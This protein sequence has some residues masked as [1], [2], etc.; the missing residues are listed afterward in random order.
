MTMAFEV[1]SC[2]CFNL[3]TG[4]SIIAVLGL[5]FTAVLTIVGVSGLWINVPQAFLYNNRGNFDWQF[6]TFSHLSVFSG[7][8][9]FMGVIPFVFYALLVHGTSRDH[10]GFI[11]VW[12]IFTYVWLMLE[13][14]LAVFIVTEPLL[15]PVFLVLFTPFLTFHVYFLVVVRSYRKQ[16]LRHNYVKEFVNQIYE[17][18]KPNVGEEPSEIK[19]Y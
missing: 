11:R 16:I 1:N 9:L 18:E 15:P 3:K 8:F 10:P 13:V 19:V 4:S 14:I 12:I 6:Y 2:C 5:L 17:I 7:I